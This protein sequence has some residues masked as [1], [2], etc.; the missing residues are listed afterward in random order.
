MN[1]VDRAKYEALIVE[2]ENAGYILYGIIEPCDIEEEINLFNNQNECKIQLNEFQ[3][4]K[5]IEMIRYRM[6]CT[7]SHNISKVISDVL[8][9]L[10][11]L[12]EHTPYYRDVDGYYEERRENT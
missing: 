7:A 11:D 8:A 9:E 12:N 3:E 1:K 2:V 10:I 6:Q 5:M 4:Q